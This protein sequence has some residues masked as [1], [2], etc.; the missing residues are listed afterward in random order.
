MRTSSSLV[1][2]CL[3]VAA[4][5]PAADA[6]A[7]ETFDTCT[8]FIDSV[9][10]TITTQGTWCLRRDL[11]T[12]ITS[13][14]AI[15]VA[16]NNVT[17]DCNNFKLGGLAAGAGTATAGIAS[18]NR[19]NIGVRNCNVRGFFAGVELIGGA[20]HLVEHS[21]FDN[22]TARGIFVDAPNSLVR[23]NRILDTGG[24]TTDITPT[25]IYSA[26]DLID[27]IVT[28]VYTDTLETAQGIVSTCAGCTIRE[29]VVSGIFAPAGDAYGIDAPTSAARITGNH[30]ANPTET[31]GTGIWGLTDTVCTGNSSVN[32]TIG[33]VDCMVAQDNAVIPMPL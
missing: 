29:N 23:D 14:A 26:G 7:A 11:A 1:A 19:Q 28:N 21:R 6:R 10:A 31:T 33:I 18:S 4:L 3:A 8:G 32:F 30:V 22:N 13:G 24:S 27:N 5:W 20:G 16:T 2:L 15:T 25:G 9:P 12:A 17:I